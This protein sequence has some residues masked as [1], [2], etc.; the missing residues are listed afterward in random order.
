MTPWQ[1]LKSPVG[2][3]LVFAC[4]TA[5][6]GFLIYRS[7]A[8][9][10]ARTEQLTSVEAAPSGALRESI[11]RGGVPMKIPPPLPHA[12]KEPRPAA[13]AP[14]AEPSRPRAAREAVCDIASVPKPKVLPIS[15]F[16][17][18][19]TAADDGALSKTY[20]P[21]G[22]MIACETVITIESSKLDTPVIGL[23]TDDVWHNGRLII[24]AGTEVHGRASLD[25]ARERI[26]A[27]G[28]WVVVWRDGSPLN[29]TELVLSGIALDRTK[30]EATG[31]FGL[32]DG[33]AGLLGV[34][35][36]TDDWQ[37]IKLFASTFVAGFAGG[38]QPLRNQPT[39]FGDLAQV[40]VASSRNAALQGTADVLNAYAKQ[41]Q[42][43]IARDGFFVRVPAGKQFYLYVTET[44][45]QAKGARGNVANIEIWKKS[46]EKN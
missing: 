31:E 2:N 10:E 21:Y 30:D 27:A 33:S 40:P 15:L 35:I 1:F 41:I 26:A 46:H 23:V 13:N 9:D 17:G 22:R 28:R 44:I 19:S 24:P 38:L 42:E 43:A 18:T 12:P 3:L 14:G 45:D 29:G 5:G 25:R 20:A 4:F 34:L 8:R 36:K 6:G 16:A 11:V 32:R 39:A 37:E 7:N